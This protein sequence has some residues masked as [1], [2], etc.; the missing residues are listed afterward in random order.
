MKGCSKVHTLLTTKGRSSSE[1]QLSTRVLSL[2]NR[3]SIQS[4]TWESRPHKSRRTRCLIVTG[5]SRCC[6]RTGRQRQ[7]GPARARM[8]IP[9]IIPL[10]VFDNRKTLIHFHKCVAHRIMIF[11]IRSF[12]REATFQIILHR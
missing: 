1:L 7:R 8:H 10:G 11:V 2:H 12:W 4:F 3:Q 9:Y 6:C 5:T